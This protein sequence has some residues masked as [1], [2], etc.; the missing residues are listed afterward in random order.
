MDRQVRAALRQDFVSCWLLAKDLDDI[1]RSGD[2]DLA[3]VCKLIKESYGYPVDSVLLGADLRVL[4]HVNVHEP[5]GTSA[6][7]YLAFL[8]DGLAKARGEAPAPAAAEAEVAGDGNAAI[9]RPI[10]LTAAE[11]TGSILD[12]V[13]R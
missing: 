12:L 5:A 4:G 9:V 3:Q 1:A 2:A 8:R 10:V 6:R 7:L 13:E 11:P